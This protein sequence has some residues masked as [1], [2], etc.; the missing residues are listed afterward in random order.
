MFLENLPYYGM[1]LK[2]QIF[3]ILSAKDSHE[4]MT[5]YEHGMFLIDS[6][7]IWVFGNFNS[8]IKILAQHVL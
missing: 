4:I 2:L 5:A 3:S 8:N 6:I 7:I 1:A